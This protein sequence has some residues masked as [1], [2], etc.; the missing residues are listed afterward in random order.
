MNL[1]NLTLFELKKLFISKSTWILMAIFVCLANIST[2]F[3]GGFLLL[4][5]AS[6]HAFLKFAPI[7]IAM[8]AFLVSFNSNTK[9]SK[10]ANT[11]K[12]SSLPID[13]RKLVLAKFAAN[14]TLG[15]LFILLASSFIFTIF[16]L[17]QP[18][19]LLV[20]SGIL[21]CVLFFKLC[22]AITS[23]TSIFARSSFESL[24]Y[25]ILIMFVLC[26][27]GL[28][29]VST[30]L[31]IILPASFVAGLSKYSIINSF[32]SIAS[33]YIGLNDLVLYFSLIAMFLTA[34]VLYANKNIYSINFGKA[35]LAALGAITLFVN[36]I[37]AD[38]TV[39]FDF[40]SDKIYSISENLVNITNKI[41]KKGV[42]VTFY[43]SE[44]NPNIPLPFQ[45][46]ANYIDKYLSELEKSSNGKIKYVKKDPELNENTEI[47][48]LRDHVAEIP[49]ANGDSM[50]AGIALRKGPDIQSIPY[51]SIK[52]KN[53]F[54]YDMASL[55]V[56]YMTN[57]KSKRI[58]ILT[59]LDL[60]N[61]NQTPAFLR[62]LLKRY[63][64]DL[65]PMTYPVFPMYDLVI[66]FVTPFTEPESLYAA[67]QYLINGGKMLVFLDPFF[68]TAPEDDFLMPD[69]KTDDSA[70]D[71][72]AD[73]IRFYGV[74]YDYNSIL[75]D[76]SR[77][78]TTNIPGIGVTSYPLWVLYSEAEMNKE[79]PIFS[80]LNNIIIPEGGFFTPKNI[81]PTLEYT[82]LLTSSKTS[83]TV[84]RA[85]FNTIG[86]PK[87][88]A[89]RLRG[90][91]M[92]RPVAF[93]L[94]GRFVSSFDKMPDRV[95]EWFDGAESLDGAAKIPPHKSISEKK[96]ALVAI[97][98][99]DFISDQFST[100]GEKN[101]DGSINKKTISDNQF[102]L[103]NTIDYLIGDYD[104]IALRSKGDGLRTLKAV[105]DLIVD[106]IAKKDFQENAL[107][108]S[109]ELVSSQYES[110][111]KRQNLAKTAQQYAEINQI[112]LEKQKEL[113]LSKR[114][115]K[116]YKRSI[117]T[118]VEEYI[119]KVALINVLFAPLV[120][121]IIG[122]I[123]FIRRR[124]NKIL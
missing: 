98:D 51:I 90:D 86:D 24:G 31:E 58:G 36:A 76:K 13:L 17:G 63:E 94:D 124:L 60:G 77:A 104:L 67:D 68:R 2:F 10:K 54:E 56:K 114:E 69:R 59:D 88:V 50:Y 26:L 45:R 121:L 120:L 83:Q 72:L 110:L 12:L 103:T 97:A 117:K 37:Y 106:D 111:A 20:A 41:D 21:A 4:N 91:K 92:E 33:G 48:A 3:L 101:M 78:M 64:I 62:D 43:Y 28:G 44:S 71:H 113:V 116:T 93:M 1:L 8:F 6:L 82:P 123:Y 35:K 85:L 89:S 25:S 115:L 7:S 81:L 108:R 96:G 112:L 19:A 87:A 9:E 47:Q 119:R 61:E 52:R 40:T 18:D 107:V 74:D 118:T 105:E 55:L 80:N 5:Q 100:Y 109:I 57:N 39:K 66:A 15:G 79:N 16:Y 34:A 49:L 14:S 46:F 65:I 99:M 73:L 30:M 75:G 102:F 122:G 42:K 38:S 95:K 70:F 11:I 84:S 29:A 22:F 23:F 27:T 53:F 32:N